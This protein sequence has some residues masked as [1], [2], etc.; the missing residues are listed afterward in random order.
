MTRRRCP[1]ARFRRRSA[2]ADFAAG[3]AD[4]FRKR[5]D[6]GEGLSSIKHIRPQVYSAKSKLLQANPRPAK[7][8]QAKMLGFIWVYSSESGLF[9]G[10]RRFQIKI[11]P[12]TRLCGQALRKARFFSDDQAKIV[13]IL[14]F[15][16][17][18]F[19]RLSRSTSAAL[20]ANAS[21]DV[22]PMRR[23]G[24]LRT[25]RSRTRPLLFAALR[26]PR[27]LVAPPRRNGG[28]IRRLGRTTK[29]GLQL[30][31]QGAKLDRLRQS[32]ADQSFPIE[33]ITARSIQA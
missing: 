18:L 24:M 10:L 3:L 11:S 4:R 2:K 12:H 27:R 22:A 19:E 17:Q 8:V 23:V 21:H 6:W 25:M 29:L 1:G 16:K 32:L 15:T 5:R 9:N 13:P 7:Q 14:I 33:Q 28:I 20:P 31:D 26:E 30:R